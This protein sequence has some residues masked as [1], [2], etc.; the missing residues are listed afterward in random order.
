MGDSKI[1]LW[2]IKWR[3]KVCPKGELWNCPLLKW[4]RF[5]FQVEARLR[6]QSLLFWGCALRIVLFWLL[7]Q[8]SHSQ[9]F[10]KTF[11]LMLQNP[12]VLHQTQDEESQYAHNNP[13]LS[14]PHKHQCF[15]TNTYEINCKWDSISITPKDYP[16]PLHKRPTHTRSCPSIRHSWWCRSSRSSTRICT[17]SFC[18]FHFGWSWRSN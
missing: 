4:P 14:H 9:L 13:V 18:H 11:P 3:G 2:Q 15:H 16:P 7:T 1:E 5:S 12:Q 8:S 10:Y 17:N 6:K